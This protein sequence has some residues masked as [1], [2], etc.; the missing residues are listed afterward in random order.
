MS[1]QYYTVHFI[2]RIF[3]ILSQVYL[4]DNVIIQA[5]L[6][7]AFSFMQT[8]FLIIYRPYKE[9]SV[10]LSIIAG[11]T[12]AS[13]AIL[14]SSIFIYK[15]N[16]SSTFYLEFTIMLIV[17]CAIS[18]QFIIGILVIVSSLRKIW[19]KIMNY[20]EKSIELSQI[21]SIYNVTSLSTKS[22]PRKVTPLTWAKPSLK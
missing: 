1:T 11:E 3:F 6:N 8:G 22:S 12:A 10:L 16:D 7:I 19:K 18:V 14:L 2:R 17:I 4:N 20:K 5:G 13:L 9:R 15:I 21:S